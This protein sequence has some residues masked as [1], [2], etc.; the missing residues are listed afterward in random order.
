[1]QDMEWGTKITDS[2]KF[3]VSAHQSTSRQAYAGI[4]V[5]QQEERLQF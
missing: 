1:M 2:S 5:A 3:A 4:M